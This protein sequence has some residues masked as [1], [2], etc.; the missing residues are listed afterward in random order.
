MW[1]FLLHYQIMA[2][3]KRKNIVSISHRLHSSN[4]KEKLPVP[5]I[6]LFQKMQFWYVK[7]GLIVSAGIVDSGVTLFGFQVVYHWT[8]MSEQLFFPAPVLAANI[9]QWNISWCKGCMKG[10]WRK[11]LIETANYSYFNFQFPRVG[12]STWFRGCAASLV[13]SWATGWQRNSL[14]RA[15]PPPLLGKSLKSCVWGCRHWDCFLSVSQWNVHFYPTTHI[16]FK[17]IVL[18]SSIALPYI[19]N[20]SCK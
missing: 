11:C 15:T 19:L 14:A 13:P 12:S 16:S 3:D 6:V 7:F 20:Y 9:F 8:C 2:L 1:M 5:W 10:L 18:R 17:K 4:S